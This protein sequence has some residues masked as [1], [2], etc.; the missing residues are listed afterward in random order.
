[1]A[2][3]GAQVVQ[4]GTPVELTTRVTRS[5][6]GLPARGG[7]SVMRFCSLSWQ[8][9]PGQMVLVVEAK[10][11]ESGKCLRAIAANVRNEW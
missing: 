2:I 3:P 6:G 10:V 7:K 8:P 5:E 11:D 4:A 1:M 9:L